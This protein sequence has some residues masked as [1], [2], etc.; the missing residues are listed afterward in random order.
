[1]SEP[2][3]ELKDTILNIAKPKGGILSI[4]PEGTF[5]GVSIGHSQGA[6]KVGTTIKA[7]GETVVPNLG[8]VQPEE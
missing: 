5:D 8:E 1:M 4:F 6:L 7:P 2:T 3:K